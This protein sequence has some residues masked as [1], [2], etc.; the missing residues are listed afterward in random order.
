[1]CK[2]CDD[3]NCFGKLHVKGNRVLHSC[4]R[5]NYDSETLRRMKDKTAEERSKEQR[6]IAREK[7]LAAR[8]L[9]GSE[10]AALR[11]QTIWRGRH[12][13]LKGRGMMRQKRIGRRNDYFRMKAEED[14]KKTFEYKF[15]KF[16]VLAKSFVTQGRDDRFRELLPGTADAEQDGNIVGTTDDLSQLLEDGDRIQ[17]LSKWSSMN[18]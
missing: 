15:K 4:R 2:E 18:M 13:R 1:M 9:E 5:L 17:V 6:K 12:G 8:R 11:L 10:K 3:V 7:V 14:M 16:A